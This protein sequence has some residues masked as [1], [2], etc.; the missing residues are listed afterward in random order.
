MAVFV[1]Q[2]RYRVQHHEN[3]LQTLYLE[4]CLSGVGIFKAREIFMT[5]FPSRMYV[6]SHSTLCP[7]LCEKLT[8]DSQY[9]LLHRAG[10]QWSQNI[11][12]LEKI[13]DWCKSA[14]C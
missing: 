8:A 11:I 9:S 7:K 6:K 3:E 13:I 10:G 12:E 14:C 4:T 5:G 2:E 1:V